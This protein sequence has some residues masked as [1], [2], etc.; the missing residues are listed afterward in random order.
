MSNVTITIA[1]WYDTV[2]PESATNGD[3]ESTGNEYRSNYYDSLREA[4]TDYVT[5]LRHQYWENHG[6][7]YVN[8]VAYAAD[9][10][11]NYH[12]GSED[13]DRLTIYVQ[14]NESIQTDRAK[15]IVKALNYLIAKKLNA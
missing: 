13:Y 8:E 15:R 5:K 6:F 4:A 9:P 12:T 2:T 1:T 14:S 10:D 3:Y 11:I 7:D